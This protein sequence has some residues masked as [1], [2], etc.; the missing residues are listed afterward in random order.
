MRAAA[1]RQARVV[2]RNG[3]FVDR[4]RLHFDDLLLG[5]YTLQRER[6]TLSKTTLSFK[7]HLR[8]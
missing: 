7:R 4:G 2:R 3:H 5:T 6:G 8:N 1:T